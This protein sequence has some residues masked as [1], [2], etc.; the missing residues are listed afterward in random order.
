MAKITV[1][2]LRELLKYNPQT[3]EFHWVKKSKSRFR[4]KVGSVQTL[5]TGYKRLRIGLDYQAYR[6]SRL[7]CL[8]M[9]GEWPI[10]M[11][12]HI[13]GNSLDNRWCNLRDVTRVAN[14]LN[15]HR[16]QKNNTSGYTGV[17]LIRLSKPW[18][19]TFRGRRI[20]Q[21]RTKEEAYAAVLSA[22]QSEG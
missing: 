20:G 13:N 7:A 19:A 16:L 22:R 6:A 17:C 3:G 12:D 5:S 21:F 8:Y 4:T 14:Q 10:G 1:A 15:R 2:R 11:M 9:T 18:A